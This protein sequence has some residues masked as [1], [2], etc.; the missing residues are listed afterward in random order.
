MAIPM[1]AK[2]SRIVRYLSVPMRRALFNLI[3]GQPASNHCRTQ[4]EFGG[5][6]GTVHA[7]IRRGLMTREFKLTPLGREVAKELG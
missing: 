5:F 2:P 4:S 6:T 3:N 1:T 7:L